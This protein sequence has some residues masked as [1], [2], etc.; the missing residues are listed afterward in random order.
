MH[1]QNTAFPDGYASKTT[2]RPTPRRIYITWRIASD[3]SKGAHVKAAFRAAVAINAPAAI[4]SAA[5]I[6]KD[7]H[8]ISVHKCRI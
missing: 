8:M 5:D 4:G 6:I 2:L 1:Y 7:G 3:S